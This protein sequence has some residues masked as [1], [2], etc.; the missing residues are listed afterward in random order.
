MVLPLFF[1]LLLLNLLIF[2]MPFSLIFYVH[3]KKPISSKH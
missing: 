1:G 2:L 3:S